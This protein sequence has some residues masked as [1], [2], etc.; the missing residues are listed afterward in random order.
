V[1]EILLFLLAK[2]W[3]G[4]SKRNVKA[5]VS[6]KEKP[7]IESLLEKLRDIFLESRELPPR[8]AHD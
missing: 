4:F 1:E 8:R 5:E 2:E 6:D 7:E 3:S